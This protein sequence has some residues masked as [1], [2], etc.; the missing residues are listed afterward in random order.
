M[1]MADV[2]RALEQVPGAPM[3]TSDQCAEL[4][5]LLNRNRDDLAEAA[6][7]L[8]SRIDNPLQD[9][10][11]QY[12]SIVSAHNRL[13]RALEGPQADTVS[14]PRKLLETLLQELKTGEPQDIQE[15]ACAVTD[16]IE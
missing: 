13:R 1:K 5:R 15:A 8:L 16:L 3:M 4:A 14:V 2:M 9:G 11:D 7:V 12:A 6:R 10:H